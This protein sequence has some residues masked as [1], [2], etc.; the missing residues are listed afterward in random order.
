[1]FWFLAIEEESFT[2]RFDHYT[3]IGLPADKDKAGPRLFFL[4]YLMSARG[5]KMAGRSK[6]LFQEG[7][8]RLSTAQR[9]GPDDFFNAIQGGW[10]GPRYLIQL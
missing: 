4:K 8:L 2:R 10:A 6:F 7:H 5:G 3:E 9:Y 1:L